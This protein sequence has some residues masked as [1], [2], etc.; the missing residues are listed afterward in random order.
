MAMEPQVFIPSHVGG[1]RTQHTGMGTMGEGGTP[2]FG[3]EDLGLTV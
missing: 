3:G 2:A 1:S